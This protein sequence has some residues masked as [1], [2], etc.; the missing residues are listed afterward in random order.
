MNLVASSLNLGQLHGQLN[1]SYIKISVVTQQTSD[2][3]RENTAK[4]ALEGKSIF[5]EGFHTEV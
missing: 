3:Q 2:A 4:P 5:L 1:A